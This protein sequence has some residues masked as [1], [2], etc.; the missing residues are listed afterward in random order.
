MWKCGQRKQGQHGFTLIEVLVAMAVL[1][2]LAMMLFGAFSG[3]KRTKEGVERLSDRQR[4]ARLAMARMVRELQMAYLSAHEPVT[5]TRPVQ[6]TMFKGTAGM[7]GDRIDFTAF[8]HNRLDRDARES[9]QC[10][11]SYYVAANPDKPGVVDLLRRESPSLDLYPERGGRVEV[12]ATDVDL[13]DVTFLDPL[14]IQW[15]E[16]WDTT[17]STGQL[18][19]LPIQVAITLVLNGGKR[20]S[21][22]RQQAPIRL[23]TK[24]SLPIQRALTFATQ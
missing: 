15:L 21:I 4:E 20:S 18:G 17:L 24:V 2:A 22:T 12:L 19:R 10:E 7:P 11:I 5:P 16:T 13:F 14:T 3:M 9:D 8:A 1:A 23:V 6:K